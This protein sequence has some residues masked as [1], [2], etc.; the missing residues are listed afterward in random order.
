M[1]TLRTAIKFGLYPILLLFTGALAWNGI[2]KH[3]NLVGT[4]VWIA[5]ARFILLQSIELLFPL[6]PEWSITLKS[7]WR[8]LKYGVANF[9]TIRLYGFLVGLITI[10]LAADNPGFLNDAPLWAEIIGAALLY[11]FIQYWFH[12]FSHEGK[13]WLGDKLWKIHVAHHLPDRVYLV[14]HAVMHPLNAVVAMLFVPLTTWLLG[15]SQEAVMVWFS[16]RGLHGLLSHYNVDIRAGWLNYIFIGTELHRYHHSAAMNECKNYGSLLAFW[17]Q[18]F[19]TFV[20]RPGINPERLGVEDPSAYP[21]SNSIFNVLALPFIP[22]VKD[23]ASNPTTKE[24]K[25][26]V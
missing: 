10:Q 20:Y 19:G 4:F 12:R 3:Y 23:S 8:D 11:E 6:K 22:V 13:G 26:E 17:D 15:V 25:Q 24:V 16:F 1:Q 14:M 9:L 21:E 18:I 2:S 5:A 7:F